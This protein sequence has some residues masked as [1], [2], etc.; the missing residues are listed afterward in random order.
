MMGMAEAGEKAGFSE[1]RA[2]DDEFRAVLEI[3]DQ[4]DPQCRGVP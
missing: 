3:R 1:G 2:A 4:L